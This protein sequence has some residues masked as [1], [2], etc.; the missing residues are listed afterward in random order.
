MQTDPSAGAGLP[1]DVLHVQRLCKRY[2]TTTAVEDVSF[3]V[4]TGEIVG[5]LGPNGAGKT[6]TINM[7]LGILQPSSGSIDIEGITLSRQ[8]SRALAHTNFA[9][10]YAT[11]P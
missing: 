4:R 5:L 6:T 1:A 10:V 8:R 9:A 2:G 3:S 11:L 7:V